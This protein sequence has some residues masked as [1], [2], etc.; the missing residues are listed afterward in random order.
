[1]PR[2]STFPGDLAKL[3]LITDKIMFDR[4]YCTQSAKHLENEENIDALD[5]ITSSHFPSRVRF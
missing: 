3:M 1:M 5:F 2:F 4:Y